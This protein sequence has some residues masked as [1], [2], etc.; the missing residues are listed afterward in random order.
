MDSWPISTSI[1]NCLAFANPLDPVA[2]G[3]LLDTRINGANI[4]K[5][6]RWLVRERALEHVGVGNFL[7]RGWFL[8]L[9]RLRR[10]PCYCLSD[11][12][13][14]PLSP[15]ASAALVFWKADKAELPQLAIAA[16]LALFFLGASSSC[17]QKRS[18]RVTWVR[19]GAM[20]V[21]LTCAL[22]SGDQRQ[23]LLVRLAITIESA[24]RL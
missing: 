8:L 7:F 17:R 23:H 19:V 13:A 2:E 3:S 24:G 14:S 11:L 12:L 10:R 6:H 15:C 16:L 5:R 1:S 22:G 18:K 9:P 4:F 20:A 21:T